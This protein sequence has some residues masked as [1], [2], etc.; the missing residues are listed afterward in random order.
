MN[1]ITTEIGSLDSNNNYEMD[2]INWLVTE[3]TNTKEKSVSI[4]AENSEG[5]VVLTLDEETWN[6]LHEDVDEMLYEMTFG[7]KNGR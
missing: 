3:D 6:N 5:Y 4:V 2:S 7:D 1:K